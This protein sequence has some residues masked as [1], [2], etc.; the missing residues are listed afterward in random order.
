MIDEPDEELVQRAQTGD[1]AAYGELV[2]RHQR[3]AVRLAAAICGDRTDGEDAAQEAVIKAHRS[4]HRFRSG[5]DFRPWLL[6]IVAN[7]AK[8]T[9]RGRSRR[10]A[11]AVRAARD[12][13]DEADGPSDQVLFAHDL[14]RVAEALA[15]LREA[16]RT[17]IALR[18]F[19]ELSER[20]MADVLGRRPGTVKSRL[21]RALA[22]LRSELED[23]PHD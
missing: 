15:L 11:L 8:N 21:S 6:R 13:E 2:R 22:R 12:G 3:A 20:E 10:Q 19:A 23:G 1:G 17:V 14:A 4:L 18:Y 9:V 5:A 16:D 7:T